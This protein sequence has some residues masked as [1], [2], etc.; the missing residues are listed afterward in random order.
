MKQVQSSMIIIVEVHRRCVRKWRKE[1]HDYLEIEGRLDKDA[2]K[3][4]SFGGEK[5]GRDSI[6]TAL[7]M[8]KGHSMFK[9]PYVQFC[10]SIT[11]GGKDYTSR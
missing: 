1:C 8:S 6:Q 11:C 2:L 5:T 3:Q 4:S 9:E 7:Q 10:F